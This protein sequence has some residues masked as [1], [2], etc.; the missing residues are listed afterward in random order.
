MLL[1]GQYHAWLFIL[2]AVA[3][4]LTGKEADWTPDVVW[5]LWREK[6]LTLAR[7]SIPTTQHLA[8]HYIN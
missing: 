7:N 3:L 1:T 2:G 8:Y 6:S 5:T 4:V